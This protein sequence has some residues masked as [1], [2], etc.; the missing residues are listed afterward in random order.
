M[1]IGAQVANILFTADLHIRLGQKNI[2]KEWA[3][4]R[5]ETL[6]KELN[7]VYD[8]YDC[9]GEI[10]GGDIFDKLP[11]LEE[12]ALYLGYVGSIE[13]PIVIYD[14]NHEA[15]RKGQSFL[16]YLKN[17]ICQLN[18]N[19]SLIT[20]PCKVWNIDFIPYTH[21][22]TFDPEDFTG[23]ILCTHVRGDIPPHVLPEIDLDRL[24]GWAV[25]FAGDLHAH[26]NSQRNIVYPGSPVTVTFHRTKVNTGVI[27][28]DHITGEWKWVE[29]K[30]P[31]LIRK[32]IEDPAEMINTDYDWTIYELVGDM[33][34]LAKVDKDIAILDKKIIKYET[35]AKLDLTNLTLEEEIGLYLKDIL[36]FS[37]D[38]IKQVLR[39]YNDNVKEAQLE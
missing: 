17:T 38:S 27:V 29:I 28:L 39:V 32:T 20:K 30:V 14:G 26:S 15:T 6:F 23:E 13:K 24:N 31:Q 1:R 33:L 12:L 2:P 5:Y 35:E 7:R 3:I 8:E 21:L 10:H 16:K 22:Q 37:N 25:V 18:K 9:I 11:S 19:S 36:N 4:N 34:D